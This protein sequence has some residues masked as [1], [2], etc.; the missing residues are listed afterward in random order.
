MLLTERHRVD[1]RD[2]E[3]T[4]EHHH[5]APHESHVEIARS[6]AVGVEWLV[7]P[8]LV[9]RYRASPENHIDSSWR[10]PGDLM[11]EFLELRGVS[12][13]SEP[14]HPLPDLALCVGVSGLRASIRRIRQLQV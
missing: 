14:R 13:E 9:T 10:R 8:V 4:K 3:F 11:Y 5:V 7:R 1:T 6:R 12:P 2:V